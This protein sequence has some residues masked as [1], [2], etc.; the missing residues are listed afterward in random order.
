MVTIILPNG[1]I[2]KI[3]IDGNT[4]LLKA[5]QNEGIYIPAIC[6]GRGTCGKCKFRLSGGSLPITGSDS[7]F[8]TREELQAGWRLSCFT[9]P[10]GDITVEIPETGEDHF[11]AVDSFEKQG[12]SRLLLCEFTP[13]KTALSF[14]RQIEPDRR[15]IYSELLEAS[16]TADPAE[17]AEFSVYRDRGRIIRIGGKNETV[18]AAAVDIG[19]HHPWFCPCG[20]EDGGNH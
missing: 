3:T 20:S 18:Y 2:R 8:F 13:R 16:K 17:E 15:L 12:Q 14:A 5:L 4:S 7:A 1:N 11:S 10:A 6:G 19:N 9:F